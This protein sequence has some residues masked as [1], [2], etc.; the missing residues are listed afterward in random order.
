MGTDLIPE[1]VAF[2]IAGPAGRAAQKLS[3]PTLRK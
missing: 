1:S 3:H 2:S